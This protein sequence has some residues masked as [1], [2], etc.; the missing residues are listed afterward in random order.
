[1]QFQDLHFTGKRLVR[2][3]FRGL[4][5][6]TCRWITSKLLLVFGNWVNTHDSVV[7]GHRRG[8]VIG[9]KNKLQKWC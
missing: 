3:F 8:P 5:Q 7:W 2:K 4:Q 6:K 1:M 9:V